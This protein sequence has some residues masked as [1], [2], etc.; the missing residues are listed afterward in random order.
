MT[1]IGPALTTAL[2]EATQA[3]INVMLGDNIA[4]MSEKQ[5]K[6]LKET[7]DL[8]HRTPNCPYTKRPFIN[9][10]EKFVMCDTDDKFKVGC[11]QAMVVRKVM[12][13]RPYASLTD[14]TMLVLGY[15]NAAMEE[16]R[17]REA[18]EARKHKLIDK[19]AN[20]ATLIEQII[21]F[22]G[23]EVTSAARDVL[24]ETV[25]NDRAVRKMN[26][27]EDDEGIL[28]LYF[29]DRDRRIMAEL[30]AEQQQAAEAA[31]VATAAIE[32]VTQAEQERLA[33]DTT[34]T[35]DDKPIGSIVAEEQRLEATLVAAL[36]DTAV[37]EVVEA[38]VEMVD[39]PA[40]SAA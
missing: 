28:A 30:E 4:A 16:R 33:T 12:K 18:E 34:A 15:Y 20:I 23:I 6:F 10:D 14:T 3:T 8:L 2:K 11:E 19:V 32:V 36:D 24:L 22:D 40:A 13:G 5:L 37:I 26:K 25:V 21:A 17:E 1:A 35:E 9:H 7:L 29:K 31:R 27:I 39:N 38:I